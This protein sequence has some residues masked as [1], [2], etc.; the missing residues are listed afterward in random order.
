MLHLLMTSG[1]MV[2][3]A[4]RFL[5]ASGLVKGVIALAGYWGYSTQ[6]KPFMK[7]DFQISLSVHMGC[8]HSKDACDLT[9]CISNGLTPDPV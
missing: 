2:C 7:Q 1:I 3:L 4:S 9:V 5:G 6:F 8:G